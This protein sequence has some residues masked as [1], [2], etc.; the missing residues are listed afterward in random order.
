MNNDFKM[1]REE[2]EKAVSDRYGYKMHK[3]GLFKR[4][5]TKI[6]Y[7]TNKKPPQ[8]G[9]YFHELNFGSVEHKSFE[10]GIRAE[11]K[12]TKEWIDFCFYSIDLEKHE[13][14]PDFERKLTAA[15]E[16]INAK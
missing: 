16:A 6:K 9:I 4:L 10:I 15:W 2:F 1:T 5:D 12:S 3:D 7:A 13:K 11:E 14:I 8:I